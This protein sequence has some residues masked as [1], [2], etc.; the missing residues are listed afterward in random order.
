MRCN[1]PRVLSR[2]DNLQ[3]SQASNY[4]YLLLGGNIGDTLAN[5]SQATSL[6]STH[7]GTITRKSPVYRSEA[8]GFVAAQDF[9]NIALEV[10]TTLSAFELLATCKEIEKTI[11]REMKKRAGYESRIIDV[12]ILFYNHEKVE[13]DDL[14]IPHPRLH[15]R[16]FALL[17][18]ADIAPGFIHPSLNKPVD[19]LLRDCEDKSTCF[20]INEQLNCF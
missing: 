17:P 9:L 15:L 5:L 20:R 1:F 3:M 16:K 8:W 19:E 18:L 4:T 11:G 12:D 2:L 13:T 10:N 14:S 6:V 7:I